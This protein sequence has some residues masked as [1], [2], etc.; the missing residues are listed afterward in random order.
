MRNRSVKAWFL[1]VLAVLIIE[2]L[3]KGVTL[4]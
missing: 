3:Y 2:M 4:L 1:I